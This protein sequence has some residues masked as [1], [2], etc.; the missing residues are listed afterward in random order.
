ILPEIC[1]VPAGTVIHRL[2]KALAGLQ[3]KA[4]AQRLIGSKLQGVVEGLPVGADVADRPECRIDRS[5]IGPA[6]RDDWNI[7]RRALRR[8]EQR[9]I[10]ANLRNRELVGFVAAQQAVAARPDIGSLEAPAP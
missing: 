10:A 3:R 1:C 6:L 7:V 2:R 5:G 4:P 9:S 8:E